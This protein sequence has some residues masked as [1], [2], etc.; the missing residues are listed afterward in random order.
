MHPSLKH[1][2][3]AS[4]GG[5]SVAAAPPAP[6]PSPESSPLTEAGQTGTQGQGLRRATPAGTTPPFQRTR[7]RGSNSEHRREEPAKMPRAPTATPT[8]PL[9]VSALLAQLPA[10]LS[11]TTTQPPRPTPPTPFK[12]P[13]QSSAPS[14]Q[15]PLSVASGTNLP[16]G[17]ST[18]VCV[19]EMPPAILCREQKVTSLNSITLRLREERSHLRTAFSKPCFCREPLAK[20]I[21]VK[22]SLKPQ[23]HPDRTALLPRFSV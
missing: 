3:W 21:R 6:Q 17:T 22:P 5:H 13:V 23:L 1:T 4:R 11:A 8:D 14:S 19:V 18:H 20:E 10:P 9:S 15:Q 12:P 7:S 16:A 2:H